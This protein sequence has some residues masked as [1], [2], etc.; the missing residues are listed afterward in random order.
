M[1]WSPHPLATNQPSQIAATDST[2]R[3]PV[4]VHISLRSGMLQTLNVESCDPLTIN[5]LSELKD[6]E[7]TVRLWPESVD[8]FFCSIRLQIRR[9]LSSDP[10]HRYLLS[11]VIVVERIVCVTKQ[12]AFFSFFQDT[13]FSD[14]LVI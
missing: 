8:S 5:L 1:L 3:G 11:G 9:V 6:V 4:Y 2:V 7:F 13:P 10:L 12:H 14:C